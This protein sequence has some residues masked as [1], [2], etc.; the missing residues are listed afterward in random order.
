MA[1]DA[2]YVKDLN[3][4]FGAGAQ[5]NDTMKMYSMLFNSPYFQQAMSENM[6]SGQQLS[7]N[8][9]QS[10][11]AR[12]LSTSGIGTLSSAFGKSASAFGGSALRGGLFGQ[13]GNLASQ[14]LM[15][16]LGAYSSWK[17]AQAQQPSFMESLGGSLL[18]AAGQ[19][20]GGPAGANI[21]K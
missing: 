13:A 20:L 11:G 10:L 5:A 19:V 21:F 1:D 3:K 2:G 9:N 15:A 7:S 8:I 4:W 16:R 18:G 17:T 6:A 14:N 12:G